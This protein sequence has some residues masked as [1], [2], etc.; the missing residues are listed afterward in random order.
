MEVRGQLVGFTFLHL[1]GPGNQTQTISLGVRIGNP[2]L[3]I[4][5]FPVFSIEKD[6]D[7]KKACQK[8]S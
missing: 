7:F 1:V 8:S 2:I 5:I 4:C 6:V 3:S